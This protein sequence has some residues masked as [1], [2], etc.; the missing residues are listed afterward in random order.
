MNIHFEKSEISLQI[1]LTS[2]PNQN[3]RCTVPIDGETKTLLFD[4]RY[5]IEAGYWAMTITDDLTNKILL[6]SIPLLAGVYPAAN[7]LEQ[8]AYLNIGSAYVVKVNPDIT[9]EN[10]TSDNLGSGFKLF[11]SDTK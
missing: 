3:F 11:W 4:V 9:E 1:P 2:E 6:D 7:L 10:P 8:Y 5:N